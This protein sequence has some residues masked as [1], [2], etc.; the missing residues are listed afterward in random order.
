[1]CTSANSE[2]PGSIHTVCYG[3]KDLQEIKTQFF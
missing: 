3:K 2:D 1:M